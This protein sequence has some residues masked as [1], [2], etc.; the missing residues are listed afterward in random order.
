MAHDILSS[1]EAHRSSPGGGILRFPVTLPADGFPSHL[2][3]V[4]VLRISDG[5][6]ADFIVNFRESYHL[7]TSH[8]APPGL[9]HRP[10]HASSTYFV[11]FRHIR[12]LF[13]KNVYLFRNSH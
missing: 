3:F 1:A 6:C 13:R 5:V 12:H 2:R 7:I 10:F 9:A 11:L 4:R 8:I